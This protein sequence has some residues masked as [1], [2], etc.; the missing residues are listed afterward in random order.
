MWQLK[1]GFYQRSTRL[2]I[3]LRPWK[4]NCVCLCVCV[5]VCVCITASSLLQ[6]CLFL[7]TSSAADMCSPPKKRPRHVVPPPQSRSLLILS[8]NLRW[9]RCAVLRMRTHICGHM[10][11]CPQKT[12]IYPHTTICVRIKLLRCAA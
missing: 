11:I 7:R 2:H 9:S 3:P 12:H 6:K 10:Y 1:K 8:H 4:I 5:C